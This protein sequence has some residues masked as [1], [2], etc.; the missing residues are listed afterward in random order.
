MKVNIG[1]KTDRIEK[2]K[3]NEKP[4]KFKESVNDDNFQATIKK[5][6]VTRKEFVLSSAATETRGNV[7]REIG[8]CAM[9]AAV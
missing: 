3:K 9:T 2:N 6:R 4:N 8:D 5:N 7:A 1:N